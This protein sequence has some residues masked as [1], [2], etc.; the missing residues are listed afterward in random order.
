MI[1]RIDET[2]L[3]ILSRVTVT[4]NEIF[5]TCGTLDRKQYQAVNE[6]LENIGGKWNRKSKSHVFPEDPTDRLE[7]VLLRGE[8]VPPKKYGYFPTPPELAMRVV[9]EAEVDFRHAVLEP[10]AGQGGIADCLPKDCELDCVELLPENAAVLEK[11]M[12][13]V[14]CCDFL[15][16][17][18]ITR[19]DRVVMNPPFEKQQDIDHVLHA[20]KFLKPGGRLVSI[21]SAGVLFRENRKT[22]E[23]QEMICAYGNIE[24]LPENSFKE[25]GTGVNTVLVVMD[26]PHP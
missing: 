15:A 24:R 6:V 7:S 17:V 19:Y 4:G 20:W 5:L 22:V 1:K 2:T 14:R 23:F 13:N 12:Y 26:K 16:I 21:M 8:I 9:N 10:S 18:P 3:T 11:K 25:S